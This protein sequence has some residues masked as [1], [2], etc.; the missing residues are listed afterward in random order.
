MYFNDSNLNRNLAIIKN[1]LN[2]KTNALCTRNIHSLFCLIYSFL[3]HFAL[4]SRSLM[5]RKSKARVLRICYLP[6]DVHFP[7]AVRC[8][9]W[10]PT[11]RYVEA[12]AFFHA[13]SRPYQRLDV[14]QILYTKQSN[15]NTAE[16]VQIY[17]DVCS[18][19]NCAA[20]WSSALVKRKLKAS[21]YRES[22]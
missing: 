2:K 1:I 19:V 15:E 12:E 6:R 7:K 8:L 20:L 4:G 11:S 5:R 21:I 9:F 22:G 17:C 14:Q 16:W 3:G 18:A 13:S 10:T